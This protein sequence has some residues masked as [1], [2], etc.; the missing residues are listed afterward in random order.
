[1]SLALFFMA[2]GCASEPVKQQE[3]I[4]IAQKK[5]ADAVRSAT[6]NSRP[7][8][9][10]SLREAVRLDPMES[11]YRW[12]LARAYFADGDLKQAEKEFQ[13]TIRLNENFSEA[14]RE[15]GRLYMQTGDLDKAVYYLKEGLKKTGIVN[16]QNMHNWIAICY[17][18]Q[19]RFPEA[20]KEWL[21]AL[22][23]EENENVLL[24][25]GLAYRDKERFDKAIDS[26]KR[27][28]TINP[29][30]ATGHYHLALL[31]LKEKKKELASNHFELAM[32]LEPDN[33]QGRSAAEYLRMIK[34]TK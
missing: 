7:E 32:Q 10:A 19:N 17:Y 1:M 18:G 4:F 24:N 27:A 13:Q 12:E 26:L 23:I 2:L 21:E 15:L 6:S 8:M 16:P 11:R 22:R 5:F 34:T 28:V 9:Y 20:E 14:F 29:K 25:L 3:N 31:Y 30:F 33:D